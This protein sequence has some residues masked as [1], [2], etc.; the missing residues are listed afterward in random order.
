MVE[1][2][3]DITIVGAGVTGLLLA[4]RI[5][6]QMPSISITVLE[7]ESRLG[8]RITGR[9][10]SL[11]AIIPELMHFWDQTLKIDPES[12]D[13]YELAAIH[14]QDAIGILVGQK[15]RL[16]ERQELFSAATIKLLGNTATAKSW[17]NL[18]TLP[19]PRRNKSLKSYDSILFSVCTRLALMSGVP[20]TATL[21][22]AD[23]QEKVFALAHQDR[24]I[25]TWTRACTHTVAGV[26]VNTDC[27]VVATRREQD[28]WV[29]TTKRGTY[30]SRTL[31][32]AHPP[33][34]VK[35][36]LPAQYWPVPLAKA[37][38]RVRPISSV[39]LTQKI[40]TDTDI[41]PCLFI[42]Q[43]NVPAVVFGTEIVFALPITFETRLNAPKVAV[44]VTRLKRAARY[45]RRVYPTI[46]DD[47]FQISLTPVA[48][49]S[50]V[51]EKCEEKG[52]NLFFC[53][54][55]YGERENGDSNIVDSVLYVSDRLTTVDRDR[56]GS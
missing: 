5:H 11:H 30:R 21:S 15:V 23:W 24:S 32:V 27:R 41:L 33:W 49:A 47:Q 40:S 55:S 44:A 39:C 50:P 20:D 54:D 17:E 25:A 8:G 2:I 4:G 28:C 19:A 37:T 14:K 18:S 22:V 48:Y 16:Y 10:V 56:G 6:R 1:E 35:E 51:G 3:Q 34:L 7:Q 31:V 29:L 26:T 45:L 46:S 52:I 42:S 12:P 53:G 43:E 38:R 36:W 13:L 9:D